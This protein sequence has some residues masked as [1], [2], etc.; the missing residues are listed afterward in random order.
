M[1]A[2]LAPPL[3]ASLTQ[4]PPAG[5][6]TRRPAPVPLQRHKPTVSPAVLLN[7]QPPPPALSFRENLLNAPA[8]GSL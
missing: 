3:N 8:L 2:G 7:E 5:A 1:E 4:W 6:W